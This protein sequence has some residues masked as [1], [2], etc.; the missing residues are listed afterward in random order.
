M[1]ICDGSLVLMHAISL[2][3]CQTNL[4]A[5]L[6]SYFRILT[7]KGTAEDFDLPILH[8]CLSQIMKNAKSLCKKH[9]PKNYK[10]A[11]H[12]FGLLTTA[13]SIAEFDDMLLSCTV[14]FSSPCSSENVEKHFNNIQALLT[15]VGESVVD[16][17]S[18]VS[19]DLEGTFSQTPFHKHFMKV[20]GTAP[21]NKQ[22]DPNV[23]YTETFISSLAAHFLSHAALWTSM[24]LGDLGR[25]GEGPPY[26]L[27]S[28]KFSKISKK[29]CQV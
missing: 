3:F 23:Y 5:L 26:Q 18:I 16:D 12:I 10:L 25:H 17:N 4:N 14:I 24:M 20:I 22:G 2:V 21:L 1:I 7:G 19:E 13:R 15:T 28:K 29:K 9:A 11:M 27:F 6:Q 8:R